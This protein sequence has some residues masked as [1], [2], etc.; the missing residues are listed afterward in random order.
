MP[1]QFRSLVSMLRGTVRTEIV[2]EHLA[3]PDAFHVMAGD[4]APESDELE[5]E[6]FAVLRDARIFHARIAEAVEDAVESLLGDIAAIVLGRE[7]ELSSADISA[8]TERA[9]QQF[10]AEEPVRLRA[11]PDEVDVLDCAVPVVADDALRRGDVVIELRTGTVDATLG[12]RLDAVM[13]GAL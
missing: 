12:A 7:L 11:H 6:Q 3:T 2:E 1:E 10:A 13:R 5:D 8:I 9:L 4:T